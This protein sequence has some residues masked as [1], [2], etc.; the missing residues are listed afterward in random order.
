MF[1]ELPQ[2]PADAEEDDPEAPTERHEDEHGFEDNDDAT[3]PIVQDVGEE[4]VAVSI[5][6][7]AA[8]NDDAV[9]PKT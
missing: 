5:R 8:D 9:I 7:D 3:T 6:N 4:A 1:D 2:D